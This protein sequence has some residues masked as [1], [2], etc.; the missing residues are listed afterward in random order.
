MRD[1]SEFVQFIIEK[2]GLRKPLLVEK[3]VLLHTLLHRLTRDAE[4]GEGYL[5]KGGSCLVKCYFGY[6]RF[7][8]DLDFTYLM[9]ERWEGLSRS[10]RRRELVSEAERL[11]RLIEDASRGLGLEFTADVRDRRF[12]EFGSGLG[13]LAPRDPGGWQGLPEVPLLLR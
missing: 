1:Y 7:S 5:F 13:S 11:T 8:V 10:E 12:V 4:F 9:Q 2:T 3:D 6:Y